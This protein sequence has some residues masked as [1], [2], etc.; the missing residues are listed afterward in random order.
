LVLNN[1][2]EALIRIYMFK[3]F[4]G[5]LALTSMPAFSSDCVLNIKSQA[6]PSSQIQEKISKA[7]KKRGFAEVKYN[8]KGCYGSIYELYLDSDGWGGEVLHGSLYRQGERNELQRVMVSS[9]A[10]P[11][12]I[13]INSPADNS[14]KAVLKIIRKLKPEC[15]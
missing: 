9:I 1:K 3:I 11:G 2:Q 13:H 14:D 5:L 12:L 10:M 8:D 15:E 6:T 7:A 4:I